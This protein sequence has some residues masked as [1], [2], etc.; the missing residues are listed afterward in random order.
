MTTEISTPLPFPK[1]QAPAQHNYPT[2]LIDCFHQA[3]TLIHLAEV[4]LVLK[5]QGEKIAQA[6]A[7]KIS[8]N[9]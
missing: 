6:L 4:D 2:Q 3:A 9:T 8:Q 1:R 5:L 7:P